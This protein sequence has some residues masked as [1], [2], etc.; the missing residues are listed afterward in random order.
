LNNRERFK[1]HY[2][3]LVFIAAY[4]FSAPTQNTNN[5]PVVNLF[6][7]IWVPVVFEGTAATIGSIASG[8]LYLVTLGNTA[9]D[10]IRFLASVRVR[11]YDA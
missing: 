1:I 6:K 5:I 7:K 9:A 2:D 10:N 4:N 8:A 11:F 3:K